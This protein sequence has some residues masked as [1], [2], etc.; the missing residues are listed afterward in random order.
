M[1]NEFIEFHGDPADKITQFSLQH[2][3]TDTRGRDIPEHVTNWFSEHS[4]WKQECE[5]CGTPL[6]E[7]DQIGHKGWRISMPIAESQSGILPTKW[8]SKWK[9]ACGHENTHIGSD[10]PAAEAKLPPKTVGANPAAD[11]NLSHIQFFEFSPLASLEDRD[12]IN[13]TRKRF[14][15]I[16]DRVTGAVEGLLS[17][18]GPHNM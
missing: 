1:S 16:D 8:T 6:S 5:N 2:K 14:H 15:H 7:I 11:V 18:Y 12:R 9:C 13:V 3:K 10:K 4:P 17:K